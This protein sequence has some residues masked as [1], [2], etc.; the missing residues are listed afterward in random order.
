MTPGPWDTAA[1]AAAKTMYAGGALDTANPQFY[2]QGSLSHAEMI[3]NVTDRIT[4]IWLPAMGGN[5][6]AVILGFEMVGVD[7]AAGDMM[8]PPTAVKAWQ[9]VAPLR[10]AFVWNT[11]EEYANG[12]LFISG[13][14]PA[15]TGGSPAPV[16]PPPAPAPTPPPAPTPAPAPVV[17]PHKHKHR[18]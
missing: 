8:A 13:V 2:E 16:P 14:A 7:D 18:R 5:R 6:D 10:G 4:N 12:G 17:P 1:A 3:S 9:G 11:S 15:I